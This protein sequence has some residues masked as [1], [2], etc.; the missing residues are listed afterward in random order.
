MSTTLFNK[1]EVL[2]FRRFRRT[3]WALFSCIHREV[4]IG[5]LTVAMLGTATV[6]MGA[7]KT[8]HTCGLDD[9]DPVETSDTTLLGEADVTTSHIPLG[10]GVQARQVTMLTR[11]DIAAAGVTSI[12]DVLK[13]AVNVDVRQRGGFGIQTDI[14]IDGGTFDQIAVFINGIP[15]NNPQTGHNTADF[16]FTLADIERI[17]VLDG[18]AARLYGTQAFSGAINIVTRQYETGTTSGNAALEGGSRGYL[19]TYGRIACQKVGDDKG[20][21]STLSGLYQRCDGFVDNGDFKGGKLYWQGRYLAPKFRMQAQVGLTSNDFGANTFYSP[22][23]NRQWEATRRTFAALSLQTDGR[24]HFCPRLSWNRNTDHYQ[25][26]RDTPEGENHN[27]TDVYDIGL[28]IWIESHLGRTA[29]GAD[30]RHEKLLSRNMGHLL[31]ES[32]WVPIPGQNGL[33]YNRKDKRTN[34]SYH[35]EHVIRWRSI[36]V[37]AGFLL[38]QNTTFDNRLRIYPG[39]DLT[40]QPHNPHLR[41]FASWNKSLRLPTF[42]DLWYKS[43]TQEGNIGLKPEQNTSFR[44]G[45]DFSRGGWQLSARLFYNQGRDMIDWVMYH[46]TD[47]YHATN[48]SLD[49]YGASLQITANLNEIL[50]TR[51]LKKLQVAYAYQHQDRKDNT[52]LFRSNYALEYLRHKLTASLC[53]ALTKTIQAQFNL[54]LRHRNGSYQ[55][56][57]NLTPTNR[58]EPYGTHA[59]LDTRITWRPGNF[60]CFADIQ[61]ITA[62][63][64]ADIAGVWQPARIFRIGMGWKF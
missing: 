11:D 32:E 51:C 61:N 57:E 12:S 58:L 17:E 5:V 19:R 26:K 28:N 27:R 49:S 22:A 55:V 15:Y 25:W 29:I 20:F 36:I 9:D 38:Q 2:T 1:R 35:L 16:P 48:F 41:I 37:S 53:L 8:L 46:A 6:C 3:N 23:N 62:H 33:R 24:I 7:G 59:T 60:E 52:P 45:A 56:Y 40:F 14:S 21:H 10:L 31:P 44:L 42:T 30:I 18:A 4:R 63:R 34:V 64:Y 50:H 54:Q 39:I 47:V 43:P 13:T